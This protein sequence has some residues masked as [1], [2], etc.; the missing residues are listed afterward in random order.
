MYCLHVRILW[1]KSTEGP[2][3]G[4]IEVALAV[5]DPLSSHTSNMRAS[6]RRKHVLFCGASASRRSW[7]VLVRRRRTYT[8]RL[9]TSTHPVCRGCVVDAH[10]FSSE[11][12][13]ASSTH[14]AT[15][16]LH[17]RLTPVPDTR[18]IASP[19]RKGIRSP[20]RGGYFQSSGTTPKPSIRP[21]NPLSI[22]SSLRPSIYLSLRPS[23]HLSIRPPS[24][25]NKLK[26]LKNI[27]GWVC[28]LWICKLPM[29]VSLYLHCLTT[30]KVP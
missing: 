19:H 14:L 22:Y 30:E 17:C 18:V 10:E 20:P 8:C 11:S 29:P 12:E 2:Y 13:V 1:K 16:L 15:L 3:R 25:S 27:T 28:K 21:S 4:T 23:I 9:A 24:V 6:W 5:R 26:H 7:C